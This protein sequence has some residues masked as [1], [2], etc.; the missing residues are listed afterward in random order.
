MHNLRLQRTW[1]TFSSS[2]VAEVTAVAFGGAVLL[3]EAG[4]AAEAQCSAG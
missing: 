2:I 3:P 4:H 1:P